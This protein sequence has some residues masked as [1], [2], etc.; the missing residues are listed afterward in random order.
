MAP[1]PKANKKRQAPT[2]AGPKAKKSHVEKEKPEKTEKKR[3][4]PITKPTI[5]EPASDS[6][7]EAWE[8]EDGANGGSEVDEDQE[9]DDMEVDDE[10]TREKPAAPRD[11]NASREAHKVQRELYA[12]RRAAKPH[13][14]LI[15]DA[16]RL[17]SL[18]RQK[19]V[20][21]PQRQKHIG[22]LMDVLRGHVQDIIFKHDASRIVQTVVKYGKQKERD[23][24]AAELKGK[25]RDLAQN[26]YSK[27]LVTKILR[28]CS[29]HRQSILLEFQGHVLRLLL[30]REAT[31][32]LADAYELY[33]NTYER[34]ILLRDFYGKEANLF[35]ITKGTDEEKERAKKGLRGVLEGSDDERRRRLLNAVKENVITIFN[36]P[37]K[38]AI[39]HAI[40]H[41]ALWEYL[42]ALEAVPDSAEQEKLRREIFET[43]Q[44]VLAELVHTRDGSRVARH[45]LAYGTAKDRKQILKV[46]KPHTERMCLDD[47]A[48]L[49]L[50]TALDVT[51]DTKLTGKSIAAE[52]TAVAPKLYTS[53]QGR[54]SILYL[55][56]PRSSR[57]FIRAQINSLAETDEIRERTSK[58]DARLREEEVRK[59][60]SEPLVKW[61]EE[62]G[63]SLIR[64]PGGSLVVVD[65]MLYADGDKSAAIQTLL[66]AVAQNYPS[67]TPEFPHPIDLPHTSRLYKTLL[68]GGHFSHTS[69]SVDRVDGGTWD[70]LQFALALAD[71]LTKD[72]ALSMCTEGDANGAFVIAA[73]CEELI[74]EKET[75]S[76]E[77]GKRVSEIKGKLKQW[78]TADTKRQVESGK[79]KGKKVLLENLAALGP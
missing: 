30:H 10:P 12:Q 38:G 18:A 26:R 72:I 42:H 28:L 54:R 59:A 40:V 1:I 74:R 5:I 67:S 43:C 52:I 62:K 39:T 75:G 63:A 68:Q 8:T 78:F 25:Y 32:V 56:L 14:D 53:P 65:I 6:D 45:F 11:P 70:S 66:K 57:H 49:V 2:Q 37:D 58:K 22:Q 17:W 34:T 13:S 64:D 76:E 41:R 31:S 69:K 50:F 60:A 35:G 73:L 19:N 9:V 16:K 27:F 55:L 33:A 44:D 7:E 3:S 79:A 48:Q 51:D 36:N 47:E 23:E 4:I 15:A 61:V 29:S 20:P 71:A 77:T 21:S 46:F 24:I